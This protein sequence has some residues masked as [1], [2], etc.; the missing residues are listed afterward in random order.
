M[1]PIHYSWN[2]TYERQVT[3]MDWSSRPLAIGRSAERRRSTSRWR[4]TRLARRSGRRSSPPTRR[5]A[6]ATPDDLRRQIP[7]I[8]QLFE[9]LR[10]PLLEVPGF[11]ADDVLGTVVDRARAQDLDVVLRHQRQG[12]A[13]AREP[14]GARARA[15]ARAGEQIVSTRTR[16]ARSGGGDSGADP[17]SPRADGRLHRQHPRRPWRGPEDCGQAHRPVR[18][19]CERPLRAPHP[20]A[21]ASCARRLAAN[22][23][24]ALLSRELATVSTRVPLPEDLEALRRQEPDW[25]RLRALWTELEFA[26]L[27]RQLRQRPARRVGRARPRRCAGPEALA[28]F[29]AKVPAGEPRRRGLGGRGR[30]APD[31]VRRRFRALHHSRRRATCRRDAPRTTLPDCAGRQPDRARRKRCWSGGSR[32]A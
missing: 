12:H 17:R 13:P 11:E 14:R 29:L 23:E 18:L 20:R 32:A 22:R 2:V 3:S 19:A 1:A 30:A 4:G 10:L 28:A 26:A 27:L 6:P 7:V 16:C 9:A 8:M 25:E 21:R 24:Q 31:S 5:R 15:G